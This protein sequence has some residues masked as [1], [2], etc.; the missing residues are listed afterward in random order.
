[1]WWSVSSH[2]GHRKHLGLKCHTLDIHSLALSLCLLQAPPELSK[3]WT[4]ELGVIFWVL[5]DWW[6]LRCPSCRLACSHGLP[7]SHRNP[8]LLASTNLGLHSSDFTLRLLTKLFLLQDLGNLRT[9]RLLLKTKLEKILFYFFL[10]GAFGWLVG[11]FCL[12][13]LFIFN[14]IHIYGSF[15][16]LLWNLPHTRH[17]WT[18]I[19]Q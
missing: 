4:G 18:W 16:Y 13:F 5:C 3:C 19:S 2:C 11:L 8:E 1:M 7:S 10:F 17:C 14:L 9:I 15:C 6:V 12:F